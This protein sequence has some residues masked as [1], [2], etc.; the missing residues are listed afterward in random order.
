M[1]DKSIANMAVLAG[2]IM[3]RSG[4]ETYRVE[5]TIKHILDTAGTSGAGSSS[6]SRN[7]RTE[8]DSPVRTES[9]VMLTGII[10]TI[11]RPGQEAVTVMRRVHDRGTNMHRIVEV[12]EISRKYCAGELSAEETWE[13]LKSIKGRQYTVW[14]YNIATVLVPAGFAPLFG[15]GLREI[16]AA[17]AVGVLL[18]VVMTVG[19]RLRISSFILNMICAGGVAVAAMALKVWNPAL[20]MDTV[21]IS[22][23]MTLVPGVAITNAIRDTLRGD[24]ISGGARALEAFVT[25]AAVAIGAGVGIAAMNVFW[26]GGGLL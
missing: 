24:Y 22:G 8:Q 4:A 9:L 17:A 23:I 3:L 6:E 2:E 1:D 14:M 12:N 5:D 21:I 25:A 18:A 11:E 13:K 7:D 19:K 20:N 16:P 10:V 15:G 26:R